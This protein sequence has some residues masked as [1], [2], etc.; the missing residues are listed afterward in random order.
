MA[1]EHL[2]EAREDLTKAN[3]ELHEKRE[4][5]RQH[6]GGEVLKGEEVGHSFF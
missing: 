6:D 4:V 5:V 3:L 2:K 1:A